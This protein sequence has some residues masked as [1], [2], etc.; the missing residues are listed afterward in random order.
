MVL[1]EPDRRLIE[2]LQDGLPLVSRPYAALAERAGMSEAELIA[3]LAEL[4]DDGAIKRMG[5]VVRHHELG[6]RANAMVV[7]DVP[8]TQVEA[9][10]R[11][12]GRVDCVNL[13]YRRPRRRPD[14]PYNLFCMIHGRN[15]DAV[16]ERVQEIR[17]ALELEAIPFAV[18][19]SQRR[20]KQRGAR[21]VHGPRL[22]VVRG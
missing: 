17:E 15:R 13:C 12:L 18:L 20:F 6:Y 9:V 2:A 14:W 10:G 22:E 4:Q 8:D 19:F 3:R 21:Y 16:L 1:S 7:W 11:R 5:V